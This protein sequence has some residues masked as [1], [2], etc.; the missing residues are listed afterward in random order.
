MFGLE[1]K[2][3]LLDRNLVIKGHPDIKSPSEHFE[4]ISKEINTMIE[5]T[6]NSLQSGEH[7]LSNNSDM[8]QSL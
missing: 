5:E 1:S 6:K 3:D 8:V 4:K 2:F 7:H